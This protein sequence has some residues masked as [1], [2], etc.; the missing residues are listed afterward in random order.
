MR[1]GSGAGGDGGGGDAAAPVMDRLVAERR[2]AG[3]T[4]RDAGGQGSGC[5]VPRCGLM[6]HH[7]ALAAVPMRCVC[8]LCA[9]AA[10]LCELCDSPV[11]WEQRPSGTGPPRQSP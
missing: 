1:A 2:V 5:A 6:R 9:W 7:D 11:C 10:C 4:I 8:A 3:R